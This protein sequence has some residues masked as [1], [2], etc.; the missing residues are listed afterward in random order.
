MAISKLNNPATTYTVDQMI[1][2]K[3]SDA[4]TYKNFSILQKSLQD[5]SLVYSIDNVIYDYMD[6]IN[7]YKRLV[8]FSDMEV[9]KYKYKPK[10]F[11][12]DVYGSTECYFVIM[13][14][15]GICNVKEFDLIDNTIWALNPNDMYTIMNLISR[16]EK[17]RIALNRDNINSTSK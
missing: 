10:L 1:A 11:S 4:I 6:E 2:L 3:N 15:N 12:Y 9:V 16:A 14:L 13:A 5:D 8:G 7:Q 17:T